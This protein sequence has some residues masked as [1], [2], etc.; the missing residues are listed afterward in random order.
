MFCCRINLLISY[1][2]KGIFFSCNEAIDLATEEASG[3]DAENVSDD[4]QRKDKAEQDVS[5]VV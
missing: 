5:P 3:E 1:S 2:K 4:V